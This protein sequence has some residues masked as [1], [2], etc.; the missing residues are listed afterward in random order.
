MFNGPQKANGF[1]LLSYSKLAMAT[2]RARIPP[3]GPLKAA[4]MIPRLN[5]ARPKKAADLLDTAPDGIGLSGL[6]AASSSASYTSFITT[7]PAYKKTEDRLKRI[8]GAAAYPVAKKYPD[9]AAPAQM[10]E[11]AVSRLGGLVRRRYACNLPS[12][13]ILL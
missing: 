4:D 5:N 10:S 2:S 3:A 12:K 11:T 9:R 1:V 7:P 8:R 6:S 13:V